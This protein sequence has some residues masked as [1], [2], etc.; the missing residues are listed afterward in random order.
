MG[1]GPIDDFN[2]TFV[3][4]FAS[5]LF[6]ICFCMVNQFRGIPLQEN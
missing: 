1:L 3:L 6:W 2:I 4:I 5:V